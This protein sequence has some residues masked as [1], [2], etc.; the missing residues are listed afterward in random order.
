MMLTQRLSVL[1]H[2]LAKQCQV[3]SEEKSAGRESSKKYHSKTTESGENSALSNY[4]FPCKEIILWFNLLFFFVV[5]DRK[6]SDFYK[7]GESI[8]SGSSGKVY[9]GTCKKTGLSVSFWCVF[10]SSRVSVGPPVQI[11]TLSGR[12]PHSPASNMYPC[13]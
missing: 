7:L 1:A 3:K 11:A 8:G 12:C 10:F 4:Q 13:Y 5:D 9:A 6:I 2:D